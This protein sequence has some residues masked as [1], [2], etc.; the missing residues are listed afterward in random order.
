M[1]GI[2]S[3]AEMGEDYVKLIRRMIQ[4]DGLTRGDT[5]KLAPG[6]RI[7]FRHVDHK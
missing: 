6:P 4:R 1:K 7:L 3:Y 2:P 5:A